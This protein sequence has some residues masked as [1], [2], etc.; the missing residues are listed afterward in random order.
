MR[1]EMGILCVGERTE[2]WK[3][4]REK[5]MNVEKEWD[6]RGHWRECRMKRFK[7]RLSILN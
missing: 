7:R 5:T 3:R 2:V 1:D 6:R 4:H